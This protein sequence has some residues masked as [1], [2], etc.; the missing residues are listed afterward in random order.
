VNIVHN[1]KQTTE[2]QDIKLCAFVLCSVLLQHY[3]SYSL[4]CLFVCRKE[5]V[6]LVLAFMEDSKHYRNLEMFML[7]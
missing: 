4:Q 5:V 1:S 7:L 6:H 2:V 3:V